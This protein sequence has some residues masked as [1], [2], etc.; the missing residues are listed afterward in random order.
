MACGTVSAFIT[1]RAS[2]PRTNSVRKRSGQYIN[3]YA[4]NVAPGHAL[5]FTHSQLAV[6]KRSKPTIER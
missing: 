2:S 6:A 5:N 1:G 3:Q 4:Q